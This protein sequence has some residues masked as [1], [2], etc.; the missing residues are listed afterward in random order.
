M[1][2]LTLLALLLSV[3]AWRPAAAQTAISIAAARAQAP[4]N[5]NVLGT[6]VTVRGVVTNGPEL[7]IVRYLQ[8]GTA[9]IA[10][11]AGTT[12]PAAV[13]AALAAVR[14]GDSLVVTGNL[15]NF[16]SLLELDPVT[17]VTVLAGNRPLPAPVVLW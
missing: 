10:A 9:G 16:N 15:R 12:S 7:G 6:A 17:S 4:A 8:D 11:Y 2:K 3:A 13:Q 14:P 1:K 5:N